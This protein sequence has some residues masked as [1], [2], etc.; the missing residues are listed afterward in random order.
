M[1]GDLKRG[2]ILENQPF[3]LAVRRYK[4][5][6]EYTGDLHSGDNVNF[7]AGI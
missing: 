6:F 4:K 7:K 3:V 1:L 2:P 5:C